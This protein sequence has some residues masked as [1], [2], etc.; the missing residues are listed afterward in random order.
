MYI[1]KAQELWII[2]YTKVNES[3]TGPYWTRQV[4]KFLLVLVLVYTHLV[5]MHHYTEKSQ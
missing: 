1:E 2:A 3:R 4:A 5:Y